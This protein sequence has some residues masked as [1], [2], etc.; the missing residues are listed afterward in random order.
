[1]HPLG[2]LLTKNPWFL[3]RSLS[4]KELSSSV[5]YSRNLLCT[6]TH[7]YPCASLFFLQKKLSKEPF[8]P[9]FSYF[10][11]GDQYLH[12]LHHLKIPMG[13]AGVQSWLHTFILIYSA[14]GYYTVRIA[15]QLTL[16]ELHKGLISVS[17]GLI[18]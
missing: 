13:T 5:T 4:F 14:S 7:H 16:S 8:T 18:R 12:P 15:R 1:M 2:F 10:Q 9:W 3:W 17:A 11:Q 6:I